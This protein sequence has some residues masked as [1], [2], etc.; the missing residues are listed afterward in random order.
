MT[1]KRRL[2]HFLTSAA[3]HGGERGRGSLEFLTG[4]CGGEDVGIQRLQGRM[5]HHGEADRRQGYF[6]R[7]WVLSGVIAV[8]TLNTEPWGE[9]SQL[10]DRALHGRNS[11]I[12]IV[13]A[14]KNGPVFAS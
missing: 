3:G 5:E 14:L 7:A 8:K 13:D 4:A 2:L 1:D 6:Q 10:S 12:S 9:T 11:Q